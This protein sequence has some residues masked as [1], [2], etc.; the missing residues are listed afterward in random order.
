MSFN[1]ILH[2]KIPGFSGVKQSL[3]REG[4]VFPPEEF[5]RNPPSQSSSTHCY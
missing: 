3:E 2:T 1:A 4:F 5:Y